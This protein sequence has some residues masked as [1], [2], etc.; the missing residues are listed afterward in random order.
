MA[1]TVTMFNLGGD[2]AE[3]LRVTVRH[4]ERPACDD[5][6]DGNWL[7]C[8][9]SV[10][11]GGFKGRVDAAL[12]AEDF[13]GFLEQL[14]QLYESL[15]GRAEFA[16]MEGWLS[17]EMIGDGRG[18]IVTTCELLD[19]PGIGNRLKFKIGMDQTFLPPIIAGLEAITAKYP[20][21]GAPAK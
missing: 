13:V 10:A 5:Y 20:I 16:T 18:H 4:R 8:D 2:A 3:F 19:R 11:T 12:R 1:E 9:I 17:I 21:R 7:K 15:K 14:R 6:W